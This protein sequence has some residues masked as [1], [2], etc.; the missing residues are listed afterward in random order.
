MPLELVEGGKKSILKYCELVKEEYERTWKLNEEI[1]VQTKNLCNIW[2]YL[3]N[4]YFCY[5]LSYYFIYLWNYCK[6][7]NKMCMFG[8]EQ[9][10]VYSI[11]LSIKLNLNINR[12]LNLNLNFILNLTHFHLYNFTSWKT[13]KILVLCI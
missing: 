5:L 7:I 1:E 3:L 4:L 10:E 2:S 13:L 9:K 11:N 12:N 6:S 8:Y